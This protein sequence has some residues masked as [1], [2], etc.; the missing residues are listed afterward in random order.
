MVKVFPFEGI[1]YND[2]VVKKINKVFAPPYD[3]INE[4][5]QN[6]LYEQHDFN[7]IRLIL[8]KEFPQD[9]EYNNKYVRAAAFMEGW[10]RHRILEKSEKPAFYVY[11]QTFSQA[12]KRYTRLGFFGLIRL[13]EMGH[14]KV[15][16]HEATHSKAKV[17]RLALMRATHANLESIFSF[18]SDEK[19][20]LTKIIKKF[21]R[22]KPLFN[23]TDSDKVIH[24]LWSIDSKPAIAKIIKEMK[25]KTVFI[26][27]GHHRYEAACKFRTE[28]KIKNTKFTEDEAYNH[29]LM[30]FTPLEDKGLL[31]LPIHRVLRNL[32]YFDP[33]RFEKSLAQYF[34]LKVFTA[35]KRTAASVRK[36][37]IKE[38][39]KRGVTQHVFG[40]YLGKYQ[41][42]LLTLRD[43]KL[44]EELITED[45]P[46]AWKNLDTT[47][48]KY[49]VFDRIL[50]IVNQIEDKVEYVK[51]VDEG[52]RRV[53]EDGA[54][55][56]IFLNPVKIEEITS[57]ASKY[58]KMPQKSTYFYPKLLS[59][60]VINKIEHGQKIKL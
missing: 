16:P 58:E 8:G 57:I 35:T 36:K 32:A 47:I 52:V 60:L 4:A 2:E 42:L 56:A 12:G 53:D 19:S 45:K 20:K 21:T 18:Y 7:V 30:Y 29:I 54:Q 24:R 40:L 17:D 6:A 34:D 49:L 44:I 38:M 55:A 11:E 1:T 59:G 26:A 31:I 22:R 50:G 51:E 25:E 33:A 10:L 43:E 9:N 23:V 5:E 27:D 15:F 41:Y 14:G 39:T 3:V 28:L 13:E 37:L 46:K 48:V